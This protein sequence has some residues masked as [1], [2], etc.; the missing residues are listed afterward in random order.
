[1]TSRTA[2]ERV[3]GMDERF[4][5]YMND[6]DWSHRFWEHDLEVVYMPTVRMYHYHQR[7][8][9]AGFGIMDILVRQQTR[10]H[11]R[12]ALRYLRKHGISGK[13]PSQHLQ[14]QPQLIPN[15]HHT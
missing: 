15:E 9:K 14:E 10:W 11:I 1:M 13:R 5:H 8:S 3:G 12:D 4:F 7:Q 6:V 2:L